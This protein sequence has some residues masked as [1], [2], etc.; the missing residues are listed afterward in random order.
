VRI[1]YALGEYNPPFD[2]FAFVGGKFQNHLSD[3]VTC[4]LVRVFCEFV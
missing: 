1:D 3:D 4:D 2:W